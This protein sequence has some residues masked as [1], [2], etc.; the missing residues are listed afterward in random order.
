VII[1]GYTDEPMNA[2]HM[3]ADV[4][5]RH[6]IKAGEVIM[7]H[8]CFVPN[9]DQ[10]WKRTEV[11]EVETVQNIGVERNVKY[12]V[13]LQTVEDNHVDSGN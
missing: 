10:S 4:S 6:T 11:L 12:R 5:G 2:T 8:P 7:V 1:L 9:R 13:K 3:V